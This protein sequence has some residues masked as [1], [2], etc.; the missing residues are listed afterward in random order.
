M[1]N[2]LKTAEIVANLLD[3]RFSFLG[4]KFGFNALVDLIPGIGDVAAALLSCYIIWIALKL[5]LP[6][7]KLLL[8]ARNIFISFLIGLVPLLGDIGY[9]LYKPD[10]RN[11]A[12]IKKYCAK[13]KSTS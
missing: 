2:H 3:T 11:L 8:M 5:H 10:I 1:E 7:R 6:K 4:I 9:I 12:I 13:I